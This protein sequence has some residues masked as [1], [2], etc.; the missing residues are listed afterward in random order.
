[1]VLVGTGRGGKAQED[2]LRGATLEPHVGKRARRGR[3]PDTRL[4]TIAEL[5]PVLE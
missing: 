2:T 1:V 5:R 3:V 4:K